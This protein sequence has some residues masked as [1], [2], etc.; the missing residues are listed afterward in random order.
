M[1]TV[2]ELFFIILSCVMISIVTY[3]ADA[4]HENNIKV[5]KSSGYAVGIDSNNKEVNLVP[6]VFIGSNYSIQTGKGST[7]VLMLK[8]GSLINVDE[9]TNFVIEKYQQ[10]FIA[11]ESSFENS[12]GEPQNSKSTTILELKKGQLLTDFKLNKVDS[13]VVVNTPAGAAT[14]RGTITQWIVRTNADNSIT[15]QAVSI[16]HSV[17]INFISQLT[18]GESRFVETILPAGNVASVTVRLNAGGEFT[19]ATDLIVSNLSPSDIQSVQETLQQFGYEQEVKDL[20]GATGG[21]TSDATGQGNQQQEGENLE[22]AITENDPTEISP[23][24]R[25][26]NVDNTVLNNA[27]PITGTTD[28]VPSNTG[29]GNP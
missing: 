29:G 26:Q 12:K 2:K 9:E 13:S 27:T 7:C 14:V 6:G 24:S 5:I 15:V 11:A 20:E 1:K 18:S 28:P 23:N 17:E 19:P 10:G 16:D 8:N 21:A 25:T 3:A 4:N 22:Q